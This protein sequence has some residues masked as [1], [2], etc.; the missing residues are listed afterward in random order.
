[1]LDYL[2]AHE[3]RLLEKMRADND[4]SAVNPWAGVDL[5]PS[6]AVAADQWRRGD[7]VTAVSQ[8]LCLMKNKSAMP[9]SRAGAGVILIYLLRLRQ[10]CGHLSIL[11]DVSIHYVLI[12][13]IIIMGASR[14][15][16]KCNPG[17]VV[18]VS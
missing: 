16:V 5:R 11:R 2:R 6:C 9:S 15:A 4:K 7:A 3:E 17:Q 10:C 14:P 13:I 18:N 8:P 1:M 12:I